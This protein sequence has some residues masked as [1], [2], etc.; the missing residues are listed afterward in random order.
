[1]QSA[2]LSPHFVHLPLSTKYPALQSEQ[3]ALSPVQ[4]KQLASEHVTQPPFPSLVYPSDLHDEH[5]AAE[6]L[7]KHPV[8]QG[9]QV[10]AL[11]AVT[12]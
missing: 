5:K 12:K 11:L 9:E 7:H 3:T 2:T 8:V 6:L 10:L 1:M 4:V